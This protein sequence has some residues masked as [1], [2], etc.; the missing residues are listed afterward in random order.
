MNGE[1]NVFIEK[2]IHPVGFR[3]NFFIDSR[4]VFL[5]NC[6]CRIVTSAH[7][8]L[9][10]A[11]RGTCQLRGKLQRNNNYN[12]KEPYLPISNAKPLIYNNFHLRF[13]C[14]KVTPLA[15]FPEISQNRITVRF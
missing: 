14:T 5:E 3:G 9:A 7:V 11:L 1:R 6:T 8:A 4:I 2:R 12:K 13:D 10:P 15:H